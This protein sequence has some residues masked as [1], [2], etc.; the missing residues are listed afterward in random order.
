[1]KLERAAIDAGK[2][3]PSEPGNQNCQRTK[4]ARKEHQQEHSPVVQTNFKQAAIAVTEYF[5]GLL[6]TPLKS[7]ERIAAGGSFRFRFIPSQ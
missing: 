5:K 2:E 4:R 3:I 6:K 7:H 1:M